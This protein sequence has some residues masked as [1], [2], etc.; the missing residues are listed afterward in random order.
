MTTMEAELEQAKLTI[1]NL[2]E[3]KMRQEIILSQYE[4]EVCS[5]PPTVLMIVILG[6]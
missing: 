6:A 5:Q 1:S 2:K 3:T 4:E